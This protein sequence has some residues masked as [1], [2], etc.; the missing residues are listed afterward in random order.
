MALTPRR[1]ILAA[2]RIGGAWDA[3]SEM[4]GIRVVRVA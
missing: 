1:C 4:F 2:V 3:H